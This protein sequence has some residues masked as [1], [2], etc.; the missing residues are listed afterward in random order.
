[1]QQFHSSVHITVL[2]SRFGSV[3]LH[4]GKM[5]GIANFK[6]LFSSSHCQQT[7]WDDVFGN[8]ASYYYIITSIRHTCCTVLAYSYHF[9]CHFFFHHCQHCKHWILH[10]A[11]LPLRRVTAAPDSV[12]NTPSM[13][14]S[15]FQ[16][17]FT[18]RT[19]TSQLNRVDFWLEQCFFHIHIVKHAALTC[20]RCISILI[21]LI[22]TPEHSTPVDYQ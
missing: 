10:T 6:L 21:R 19:M 11:D 13:P 7:H 1:M 12:K 16:T 8:A 18:P 20:S 4:F 3:G 15:L 2:G 22:T 17:I 14:D 5:E 9:I